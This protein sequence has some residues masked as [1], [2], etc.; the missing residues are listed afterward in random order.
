MMHYLLMHAPMH[1]GLVNIVFIYLGVLPEV[2]TG[3]GAGRIAGAEP[4]K[5]LYIGGGT[6]IAVATVLQGAIECL[7][8]STVALLHHR[9]AKVNMLPK[10]VKTVYFILYCNSLLVIFRCV[11]RAA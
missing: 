10:D 1:P 4:G 8:M 3:T 9:C 6:L 2:F 7:C 5:S 11:F